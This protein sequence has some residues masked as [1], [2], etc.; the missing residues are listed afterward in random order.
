MIAEEWI[1]HLEIST[2]FINSAKDSH[3]K[4]ELGF[5]IISIY[6]RF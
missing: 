2:T 6:V 3:Q 1:N 4:I 5:N